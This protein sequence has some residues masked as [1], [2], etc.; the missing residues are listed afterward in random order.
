MHAHVSAYKTFTADCASLWFSS[1]QRPKEQPTQWAAFVLH[2]HR[3]IGILLWYLHLLPLIAPFP[4]SPSSTSLS[5]L[6]P[7]LRPSVLRPPFLLSPPQPLLPSSSHQS[8]LLSSC[9]SQWLCAKIILMV[10]HCTWNNLPEDDPPPSLSHIETNIYR[11]SRKKKTWRTQMWQVC[12]VHPSRSCSHQ[13]RVHSAPWWIAAQM[14]AIC[15]LVLPTNAT[16]TSQQRSL[17]AETQHSYVFKTTV[18]QPQ[19]ITARASKGVCGSG[20]C[21]E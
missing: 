7:I 17:A 20:C 16:A 4:I 1:E 15:F 8:F 9:P 19:P 21:L 12:S 14:W 6:L 3:V 13:D 18:Q 10:Q 11:N 5:S 2:G